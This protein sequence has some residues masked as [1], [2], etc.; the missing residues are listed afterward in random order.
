[1]RETLAHRTII[2]GNGGSGKSTLAAQIADRLQMPLIALDVIHLEDRGF[3]HKRDEEAARQMVRDAAAANRWVMEGVYGW[4]SEP[5]LPRATA[6]LWLD[7]PWSECRA[8][9]LARKGDQPADPD[10]L[11]W[12]EQYWERQTSSSFAG[13]RK[14]Y[15]KFA[16]AKLRLE[17]RQAANALIAQL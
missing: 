6:L 16:G 3:A 4:L 2:I 9:L 15:D 13:H 10:L 12:A 7:L 17:N 8:G 11:T 1:M 14:I 5:A